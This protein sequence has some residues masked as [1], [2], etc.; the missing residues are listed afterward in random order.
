M[1]KARRFA[2]CA[3]RAVSLVAF[4]GALVDC[5]TDAGGPSFITLG[6]TMTGVSM[7]SRSAGADASNPANLCVRVPVLLGSRIQETTTFASGLGAKIVAHRD[8][9]DVTFPGADDGSSSLSYTL[10]ELEQGVGEVVSVEAGGETFE[11]RI[12]SGCTNP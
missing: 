6:V 4:A 11:I 3:A 7:S 10:D 2:A 9:A 5:A 12:A 1:T 8:G